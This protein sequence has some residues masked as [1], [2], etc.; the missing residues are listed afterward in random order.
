MERRREKGNTIREERGWWSSNAT[1]IVFGRSSVR[2][3][4]R[5][6]LT[7]RTSVALWFYHSRVR[8]VLRVVSMD[9]HRELHAAVAR[10][11]G[12]L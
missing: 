10:C 7:D 5:T 4:G 6:P 11:A 1:E 2:I 9:A 8:F 3:S 12:A